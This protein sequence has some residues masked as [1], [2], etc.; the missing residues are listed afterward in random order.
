MGVGGQSYMNLASRL[1]NG[2]EGQLVYEFLPCL[3]LKSCTSLGLVRKKRQMGEL[4][5]EC[6]VGEWMNSY[7]KQGVGI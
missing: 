7:T 6:D 1:K 3:P 2:K 4:M 5:Y